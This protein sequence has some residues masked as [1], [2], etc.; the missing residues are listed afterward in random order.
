[1]GGYEA[2]INLL[3]EGEEAYGDTDLF[4]DLLPYMIEE[5]VGL[6][7]VTQHLKPQYILLYHCKHIFQTLASHKSKTRCL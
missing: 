5:H 7:N 4:S 1:M 6:T 2:R 3:D